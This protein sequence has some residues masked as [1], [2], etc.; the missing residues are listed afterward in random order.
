V[1]AHA[2]RAGR[3][4]RSPDLDLWRRSDFKLRLWNVATG[5]LE[6]TLVGHTNEITCVAAAGARAVSG[7]RDGSLRLWSLADA[8]ELASTR[9]SEGQVYRVAV[10]GSV[11]ACSG[12]DDGELRWW[13]L[14]S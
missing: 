10:A 6:A 3:A 11:V 7:S 4:R 8:T 13:K 2:D 12:N 5:E 14:P 1:V 9:P